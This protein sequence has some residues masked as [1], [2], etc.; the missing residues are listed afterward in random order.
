MTRALV[1]A[2]LC[3]LLAACGF[4]PLYGG[5]LAPQLAAIYVEPV[6]DRDGYAG[7]VCDFL[8]R[9]D[10]A[11]LI[12][13]LT[14]DGGRDNLVAPLWSL[15]KFEVL[16]LIDAELERRNSRQGLRRLATIT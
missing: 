16:N 5:S 9:L 8:E 14:G 10:P 12:H 15:N 2:A 3:V 13:R 4:H 6:P 7:L 1:L 11:I